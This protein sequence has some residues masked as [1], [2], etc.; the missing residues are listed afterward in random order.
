MNLARRVIRR[1]PSSSTTVVAATLVAG[2]A[3]VD[4]ADVDCGN[5]FDGASGSGGREEGADGCDARDE[6]CECAR[7][8]AVAPLLLLG[9]TCGGAFIGTLSAGPGPHIGGLPGG[10]AFR[11]GGPSM[12]L[13]MMPASTASLS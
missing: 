5:G 6:G 10:H 4:A 7:K 13:A 1:K 2:A 11:G 9:G 12:C 8:P 3:A